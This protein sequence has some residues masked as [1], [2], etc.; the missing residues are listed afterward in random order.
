M[1]GLGL[2]ERDGE[3]AWIPTNDKLTDTLRL[4]NVEHYLVHGGAN[5]F[6]SG[7]LELESLEYL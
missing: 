3:F 1:L 6:R 7:A 4:P 2:T 5:P